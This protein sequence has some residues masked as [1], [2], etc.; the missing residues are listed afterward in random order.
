MTEQK[1]NKAIE[2]ADMV[3]K[4]L[5]PAPDP[6]EALLRTV[7]EYALQLSAG[8]QKTLNRLN[9]LY[10]NEKIPANVRLQLREYVSGYQVT[11]RYHDSVEYVVAALKAIS[12]WGFMENQ[13]IKGQINKNAQ[14]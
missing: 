4:F 8:Q 10:Y 9:G 12:L 6:N 3:G 2:I 11:K 7:A 13:S 14:I 5:K 1:K